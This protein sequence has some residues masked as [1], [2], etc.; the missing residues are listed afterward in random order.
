M[1]AFLQ[2]FKKK[3]NEYRNYTKRKITI[4]SSRVNTQYLYYL[5]CAS[6]ARFIII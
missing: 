5:R 3:E 2:S 1:I 4:Y 6:D